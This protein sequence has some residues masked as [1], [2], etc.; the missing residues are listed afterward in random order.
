MKAAEQDLEEINREKQ[1]KMN[2]L[3]VVVPL[4]LHQVNTQQTL[5]MTYPALQRS[6]VTPLF[7]TGSTT[8]FKFHLRLL[9]LQLQVRHSALK[10]PEL[11]LLVY[12]IEFIANGSI[13]ADL[14][15][16]LVVD[17]SELRRLQQRIEQLHVER[18]QQKEAK[19]Q[20]R[21]DHSRLIHECKELKTTITGKGWSLVFT[22]RMKGVTTWTGVCWITELEE[23]CDTL[24]MKKF[25]RLVDLEALQTLRG[26]RELEELK[27]QKVLQ[28]A[29]WGKEGREWEV[30]P[31]SPGPGP[32]SLLS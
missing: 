5:V 31:C 4:R 21:R 30:S 12:Q 6:L 10:K 13:P 8:R 1:E 7:I 14:S 15:E 29:R 18:G 32:N 27:Q 28:E 16:A 19:V 2:E 3:E 26:N 20:V 9:G 22:E 17:S 23:Q 11:S 24:M 25:G